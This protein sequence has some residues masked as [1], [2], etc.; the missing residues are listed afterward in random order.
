MSCV[1]QTPS[2][3]GMHHR[4]HPKELSNYGLPD[5]ICS[6]KPLVRSE[7]GIDFGARLTELFLCE[8]EE[9]THP[10]WASLKQT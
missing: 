2:S 6:P 5:G 10:F 3:L 1:P 8:S 4:G 7:E 9:L